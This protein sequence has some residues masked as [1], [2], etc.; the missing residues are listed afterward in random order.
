MRCEICKAAPL[1]YIEKN[2]NSVT[3]LVYSFLFT[4]WQKK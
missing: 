4:R 2:R 3:V 1:D